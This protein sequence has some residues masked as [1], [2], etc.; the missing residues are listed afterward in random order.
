MY[1]YNI[2]HMFQYYM[3][4]CYDI[5]CI[6]IIYNTIYYYTAS[7]Y[8]DGDYKLIKVTREHKSYK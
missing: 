8:S 2:C 7:L 6:A 5:Y 1:Y 4:H 3:I